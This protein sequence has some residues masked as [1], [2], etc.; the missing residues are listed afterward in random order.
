MQFANVTTIFAKELKDTLR[1]RRT[2][3]FML[4]VPILAIP[5]LMSLLPSLMFNQISRL[6]EETSDVVVQGHEYL[7]EALAARLEESD[8]LVLK[9]P[10]EFEQGDLKADVR[11]GRLHALVVVPEGF[12]QDIAGEVAA[13][14]EI[15]YDEAEIRSEFAKNKIEGAFSEYREEVVRERLE[16]RE[17]SEKLVRPFDVSARN[18]SPPK[19]MLGQRIGFML[20]YIII[21]VCYLG[22]MYPAIDLAAGEKERGTLETLLVSPATRGE[23]VI[24]KYLVILVTGVVAA[25]LSL[26]SLVASINYMASDMLKLLTSMMAIEFDLQ[27]IL[28]LL[29]VVLPLAGV[30]AAVL[31][32]LSIYA[33]TFKEAQSYVSFLQFVIILPVFVALLPGIRMSYQMAL[34][35]VVNASLIMKDVI[36][37]SIQ[38]HFVITALLA[39]TLLAV[40]ALVFCKKWFER[41]S[42]LFRT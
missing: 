21:I 14:V 13:E 30:F 35:P 18:I 3:I 22:A 17:L 2:L 4:L 28:L 37:G 38:W 11:E 10:H 23:F 1:D 15:F 29:L 26:G 5:L 20:P 32:S 40:I 39:N 27:T 36:S 8:G 42:V 6:Q 33:R 25:F 12:N 31:L 24:G 16:K 34:I 9:E 7:P 41:E 19:K